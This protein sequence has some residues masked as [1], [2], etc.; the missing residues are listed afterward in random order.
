MPRQRFLACLLSLAVVAGCRQVHLIQHPPAIPPSFADNKGRTDFNAGRV[1]SIAVSPVERKRALIA[2]EFGGLWGTVS[3]GESWFRIFSLPAVMVSD[4]EFGADGTTV[5]A[6][7][8]RDNQVANGGGIYVSRDKGGTWSR[9]AT[10]VVPP[11]GVRTNAYAVSRGPDESG[12]WYVGTDFGVAIS[13]DNGATWTHVQLEPTFRP[14]VQAVLGF[15]G[16]QVLALG[17]SALYRSDD[18]GATWRSVITDFVRSEHQLRRQ[19]DGPLT[20]FSVGVH[21]PGL[22]RQPGSEPQQG[23]HVVLRARHGHP[24]AAHDSPGQLARPVRTGDDGGEARAGVWSLAHHG[25]D[26]PWLG[27]G[28]G[29]RGRRR[30]SSAR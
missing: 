4:V 26:R 19:Q 2:M 13:R 30:R 7:V 17:S 24:D 20:L 3:G 6:T 14:M 21:S 10:G 23:R 22:S 16:G 1:Q 12:L 28:T 27:P 5:V 18:R 29:W 8:L 9:P 11:A 25:V 15:P